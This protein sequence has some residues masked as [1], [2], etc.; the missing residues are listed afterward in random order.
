VLAIN[1][2]TELQ[3]DSLETSAPWEQLRKYEQVVRVMSDRCS[4]FLRRFIHAT[5]QGEVGQLFG[6]YHSGGKA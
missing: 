2:R 4:V 3:I 5:I 1:D 6:T